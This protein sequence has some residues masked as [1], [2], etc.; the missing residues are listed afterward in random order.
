MVFKITTTLLLNYLNYNFFPPTNIWHPM[1]LYF[2]NPKR[3]VPQTQSTT[4]TIDCEKKNYVCN[5]WMYVHSWPQIKKISLCLECKNL[6][7][8]FLTTSFSMKLNQICTTNLICW[9][10][11]NDLCI[12]KKVI[13]FPYC[14]WDGDEA[15]TWFLLNAVLFSFFPSLLVLCMSLTRMESHNI[16]SWLHQLKLMSLSWLS[17]FLWNY[18]A[19]WETMFIHRSLLFVIHAIICS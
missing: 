11:E 5:V 1:F 16:F 14:F 6:S 18:M 9:S 13:M 17:F 19:C 4:M 12:K 10:S 3:I 2:L 8:I 7:K 15:Y